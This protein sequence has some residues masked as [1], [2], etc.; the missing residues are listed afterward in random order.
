MAK[1]SI[2]VTI[3][4]DL[5]ELIDGDRRKKSVEDNTDISRS[6]YISSLLVKGIKTANS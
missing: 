5:L 1:K 6:S 2:N 3:D 4:K